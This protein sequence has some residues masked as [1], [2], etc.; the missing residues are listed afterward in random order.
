MTTRSVTLVTE[1]THNGIRFMPG[2]T[3]EM[4]ESEAKW[5]ADAVVRQREERGETAAS[6]AG[7]IIKSA[8]SKP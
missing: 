4:E 1:H 6:E 3:I 5:Y 7:K 2:Q 8:M